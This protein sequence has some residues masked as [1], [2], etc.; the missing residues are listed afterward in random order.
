M[1]SSNIT[2]IFSPLVPWADLEK[3]YPRYPPLDHTTM[4]LDEDR[5]KVRERAMY[6]DLCGSRFL[7]PALP[8]IVTN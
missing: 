1:F 8:E 5:L 4:L 6:P 7:N 3:P 2:K